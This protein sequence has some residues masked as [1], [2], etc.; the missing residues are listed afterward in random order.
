MSDTITVYGASDDLIEVEGAISEEFTAIGAMPRLLAFSD[1]T[2]LRVT[3][4]DV[5]RIAPVSLGASSVDIQ[6]AP[7]DDEEV[8]SDRATLTGDIRWVVCGTDIAH[9][10]GTR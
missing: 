6:H 1:G 4:G 9:R 8:R 7:E 2:V 5:W 10:A 3:Y